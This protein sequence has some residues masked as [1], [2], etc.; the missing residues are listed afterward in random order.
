[1][2][3]GSRY[4]DPQFLDR[5]ADIE[6][7]ARYAVEGFFAGLHPS[8]YHGFSVEYSDHRQYHPGDELRFVD[9]KVYGRTDK[10]YIKQYQQET[11]ARVC[12]VLDSSAS[13][14]FRGSGAVTKMDYGRFLAAALSHLMLRQ[15][16][17]V[18]LTLFGEAIREQIP[19]SS[20]RTH[21]H[22]LLAGLERARP[23]G[24]T[25]LAAALHALA[26][27]T[28]R[29]GL[30]ILIS[31]LLADDQAIFQGLAHLR[32]L[33]QDVLVFQILDPIEQNLDWQGPIQFEDMESDRVLRAD[34]SDLRHAYQARMSKILDRIQKTLGHQGID[35]CLCDTSQ[36]L[37]RM[38]MAYLA[39]RE[40]MM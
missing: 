10:L 34:P 6:L 28:S 19:A 35:Y 18:S 17:S 16:D 14:G 5:L 9:W 33:G 23:E 32:F 29:R 12:L 11:H 30:V 39:R 13:M 1:M 3:D 27:T 22:V 25:N 40:R 21:L 38:L 31:D 4:L 7:V 24:R 15:G 8:P 36:P 37:D 2:E 26:E 20:R